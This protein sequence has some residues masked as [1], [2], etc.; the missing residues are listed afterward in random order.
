MRLN[1]AL[2]AGE[3]LLRPLRRLQIAKYN[4]TTSAGRRQ[5]FRELFFTS[6]HRG[7]AGAFLQRLSERVKPGAVRI[8]RRNT[9]N[10]PGAWY[11][12]VPGAHI[13]MKQTVVSSGH[14]VHMRR[15][16][17]IDR[18]NRFSVLGSWFS[19]PGDNYRSCYPDSHR[20]GAHAHRR[21]D[22]ARVA[23]CLA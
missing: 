21:V 14:P 15:I 2:N 7:A 17:D 22:R 10:C 12:L 11:N 8:L 19:V 6:L 18:S 13:R 1:N 16:P 23:G 3:F 9:I 5:G 4:D 20:S